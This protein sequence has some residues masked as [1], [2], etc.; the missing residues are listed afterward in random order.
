[1]ENRK[2][3]IDYSKGIGILLVVIAHGVPGSNPVNIWIYSFHMPLFFILAGITLKETII[4]LPIKEITKKY[5]YSLL[6]P[7]YIFAT[8]NCFLEIIKDLLQRDLHLSQEIDLIIK[9]ISG[10]GIKADWF[11]VGLFFALLYVVC[12]NKIFKND[13]IVLGSFFL[14]ALASQYIKIDFSFVYVF[15]RAIQGAFFIQTGFMLKKYFPMRVKCLNFS[16]LH[17]LAPI[18]SVVLGGNHYY[19]GGYLRKNKFEGLE[20]W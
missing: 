3:W 4:D 10:Q 14:V 5:F 6:L 7:Y 15:L 16:H 11:L 1:M 18:I 12:F 19:L 2:K 17:N 8:F 9:L 20:F 13:Y